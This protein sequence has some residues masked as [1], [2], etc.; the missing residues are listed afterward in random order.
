MSVRIVVMGPSGSGKSTVGAFLAGSLGARFIDGDDLHPRENVRKM[1]A[2]VPLDDADRQP[3]LRVVGEILQSEERIVVA[4]SALR[5]V[6]RD[7]IRGEAPDTF[8][9]ELAIDRA[10]LEERM[11]LRVDHFMPAALLDSQLQTLESLEADEEGIRVDAA[12]DVRTASALIAAAVGE[13]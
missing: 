3:W 11:R 2:G 4:C 5:R 7:V 13:R 1:A 8:F 10:V 9:A 6:Y 12:A